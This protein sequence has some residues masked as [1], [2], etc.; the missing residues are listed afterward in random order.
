MKSIFDALAKANEQ[1]ANLRATLLNARN[2]LAAQ[3]DNY[4]DLADAL[5]PQIAD[6]DEK[7]AALEAPM[8][9]AALVALT[10]TLL[11]EIKQVGRLHFTPTPHA[12]SGG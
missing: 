4:P 7:I 6:L 11:S 9:P 1:I 10:A 5:N 8:D 12:G 2:S 3:V